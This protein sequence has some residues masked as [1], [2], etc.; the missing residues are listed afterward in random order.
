MQ[1]N[2][3]SATAI[4]IV[5]AGVAAGIYTM[6]AKQSSTSPEKIAGPLKPGAVLPPGHPPV[7]RG[8][9]PTGTSDAPQPDMGTISP[10]HPPINQGALMDS[11]R[12]GKVH[13]D[14]NAKFTHFRVGNSNVKSIFVDGK[15]TWVGTS[16]GVIRYDTS[17][18]DFRL[19]DNSNGLLSNGVFYINKLNGRIVVGTYGGGLSLY[20]EAHDKW[21]NINVP[22]GLADAFV[23]GAIKASNGDVWIATWSG[24][25]RIRGGKLE[26]R[27]KWD[28][29]T[30]ENTKGGLPNDWV[31]GVAQGKH[32]EIWLA[33]E[34]GLARF[35]DGKWENWNHDKG[36]GAPF[37]TVKN[38]PQFGN[39]PG[40]F[41]S[42]HA[43]Q[44]KEMGLQGV[45]VAYNPNYII[46][47][48]VDNNG[49]VWVGTWGAGLARF[50]GKKW[51]NY[52]MA[53]GLPGNH[54]FSL[55]EDSAGKLWIGTNNGLAYFEGDKFKVLTTADGLF[56]NTI[57][58]M[59]TAPDGSKWL[60]SFGGV[61]HLAAVKQ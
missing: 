38:D 5:I 34:G 20:D 1:L 17:T 56:S 26:D 8:D 37:E 47:M 49:V 21:E 31:Y 45:S 12:S 14:K 30:V 23:Y 18:D 27:S 58:S 57:F 61:T 2:V 52:T 44:E 15:I 33:T 59:A 29:Y 51:R 32:G 36:I 13:M 40:K 50:D 16:G 6:S 25:N 11:Q 48:A 42:H 7:S 9:R 28:V 41:S 10:M 35:K 55:H 54:I 53:D 3:K 43:E 4:A 19:F 22:N 39:D 24:A 46:A 60:G